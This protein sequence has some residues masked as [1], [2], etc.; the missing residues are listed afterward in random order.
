MNDFSDIF[1]DEIIGDNNL[2]VNIVLSYITYT[3]THQLPCSNSYLMSMKKIVFEQFQSSKVFIR[4][5][6]KVI[7]KGKNETFSN[8]RATETYP[9]LE[10]ISKSRAIIIEAYLI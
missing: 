6:L 5:N 1:Y 10:Q 9:K 8:S 2:I 7:N 3:K 4:T